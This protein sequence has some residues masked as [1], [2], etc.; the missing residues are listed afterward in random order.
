[1]ASGESLCCELDY[2][3]DTSLDKLLFPRFLDI[4]IKIYNILEVNG[5][6]QLSPYPDPANQNLTSKQ[7]KIRP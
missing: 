4:I 3:K 6:E 2:F 5:I 1:M 7:S